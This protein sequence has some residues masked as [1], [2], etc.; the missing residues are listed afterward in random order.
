MPNLFP[1]DAPKS[2]PI[3]LTAVTPLLAAAAAAP[4]ELVKALLD[5]GA[6]VNASD[7]R[8]MTPLML[9]VATNHQDPAVI[10]L[11]LARGADATLQSSVGETAADWARKL[12]QPAGLTL[13]KVSAVTARGGRAGACRR[14]G[15]RQDRRRARHGAARNLQPEILRGQ[16]LR[17]VSPPERDRPRGR[18]SPIEGAARR[19]QG[20]RVTNRHAEGRP[21][22]A[23][24]AR[25][26]GYQRPRDLR[27]GPGR[28]GGGERAAQPGDRHDRRQHRGHAGARR[29]VARPE[30]HRRSSADGSGS[31]HPRGDVHP[32]A[33]GLR[34]AGARR[35]TERADRQ[36]APVAAR[37]HAGDRGRSQHA[38]ARS[39]LGRCR[40]RVAE[41][42]RGASS[43]RISSRTARG[44]STAASRPT[45][46]RPGN[47]STCWQRPAASR[48]PIP[49]ISAA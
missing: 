35:R 30:R 49:P 13:L 39:P 42:A 25:A 27:V 28:A 26:D 24:A 36:G 19:R 18:R 3:A 14:V 43:S 12:S 7:G 20:E 22:A 4:A 48:P 29:V 32:V 23:A 33:E 6:N 31:D 11:L 5:A 8:G 9:A 2:G 45:P 1:L 46:T 40:R 16:R 34:P 10:R 21:A 17:L 47:R 15:R 41:E 44:A 37:R 38:A